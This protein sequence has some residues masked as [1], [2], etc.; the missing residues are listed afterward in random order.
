MDFDLNVNN[1]SRLELAKMFDLPSNYDD[2]IVEMKQTK[3]LNSITK[4][5]DI[6]KETKYQTINFLIK[7]KNI[8]LNASPTTPLSSR[9]LARE[10]EGS[11]PL[12]TKDQSKTLVDYYLNLTDNLKESQITSNN[13]S[14]HIIQKRPIVPYTNSL[15]ATHVQDIINPVKRRTI[16]KNL[17]IDTKFRDNYYTTQS[18]NFNFQIPINFQNVL[19]V[20]LNAIELPTTFNLISKHYGNNFFS[21]TIQDTTPGSLP[22]SQI[23]T[24]PNG[25]YTNNTICIAINNALSIIGGLFSNIIFE[26]NNVNN[27]SV[28]DTIV[29]GTGQMLVGLAP[30]VTNIASFSLNFQANKF[31]IQDN[32]TP[33][34]LKMGWFLGFRNG[35]YIGNLNY[36]SEGI[37]DMSGPKYLFVVVEDYNSSNNNDLFYS[38]FNSSSL[39]K[40]ILARLSMGIMQKSGN[41]AILNNGTNLIN[42]IREYFGPV[43]IN[44]FTIQLL[45]EYGRIVDLNSMDFS[46][47][48]NLITAY[49]V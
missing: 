32:S 34:P 13:N 10:E 20:Q 1:Y 28:G 29:T 21:I 49:N 31:G 16:Q 7:A 38:A 12:F 48:L 26:N 5:N 39:N 11:A 22:I 17:N 36:V 2:N 19:S 46:F 24:I 15:P 30:G 14:G 6:D 9:P 44:N 27:N 40:S 41:F 35:I 25:N 43:N 23:I 8:L 3:L 47:C 33:L 37:V 18:T 4:N 42:P 45:D